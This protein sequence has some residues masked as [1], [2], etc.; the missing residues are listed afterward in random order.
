MPE[1]EAP[2]RLPEAKRRSPYNKIP[3][4]FLPVK[5]ESEPPPCSDSQLLAEVPRTE[6]PVAS[7]QV[8]AHKEMEDEDMEDAQ[9]QG[10]S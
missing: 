2:E 10:Q 1:G 7:S 5:G 6:E 4:D 9:G 3:H 8:G